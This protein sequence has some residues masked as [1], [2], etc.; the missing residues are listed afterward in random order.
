VAVGAE[1][2]WPSMRDGG[3]AELC[4]RWPLPARWQTSEDRS[5]DAQKSPFKKRRRRLTLKN[6]G[7]ARAQGRLIYSPAARDVRNS[8]GGGPELLGSRV[9]QSK[10]SDA[11]ASQG[12]ERLIHP[13]LP[14][15]VDSRLG[16]FQDHRVRPL[17]HPSAA[18][19]ELWSLS[20]RSRARSRGD[21]HTR[22]APR[23]PGGGRPRIRQLGE[24]RLSL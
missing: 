4:L 22:R 14:N 21:A 23:R 20:N 18:Q 24:G 5:L 6:L 2:G 16:R 9:T 11:F 17:C 7:L 8:C 15:W 10:E 3:F 13:L 12:V 1:L 19:S